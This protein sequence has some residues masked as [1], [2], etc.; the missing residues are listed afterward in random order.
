MLKIYSALGILFA[1]ALA[2]H[3]Q[4]NPHYTGD[5]SKCPFLHPASAVNAAVV[6]DDF[7][8]PSLKW[9]NMESGDLHSSIR[10]CDTS[11]FGKKSIM[12]SFSGDTTEGSW[13]ML[14][15][16]TTVPPG[17]TKI[18]FWAKSSSVASVYVTAYQGTRHDS[19]E[20]F[21]KPITID[22]AWKKY[23][24]RLD[25]MNDLLFS[26]LKQDGRTPSQHLDN[27]KVHAIGFAELTLPA[28]F[29]IDQLQWE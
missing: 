27:Q 20:L 18:T 17:K 25:E 23:E 6:I 16:K 13:T 19:L 9:N 4:T 29:V 14:H 24:V 2:L 1:C 5:Q 8:S 21:G 10:S 3:G 26:H 22:T 12:I 7:E 15:C 11:R 28:S